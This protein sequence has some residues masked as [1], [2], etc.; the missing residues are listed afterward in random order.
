MVFDLTRDKTR[1]NWYQVSNTSLFCVLQHFTKI[2]AE[3]YAQHVRKARLDWQDQSS[4]FIQV[5]SLFLKRLHFIICLMFSV[6]FLLISSRFL[7][8]FSTLCNILR[9]R[10][11]TSITW[12]HA[13][14]FWASTLRRRINTLI[15]M[16]IRL[17]LFL[18]K[19]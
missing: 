12:G 2:I 18:V 10:I 19:R 3:L 4:V 15:S 6:K 16:M 13:L 7:F 17:Y 14:N 9:F 5:S 11:S 8:C 1:K